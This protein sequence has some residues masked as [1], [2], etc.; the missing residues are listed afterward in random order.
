MKILSKDSSQFYE[1]VEEVQVYLEVVMTPSDGFQAC[2][3]CLEVLKPPADLLLRALFHP[4][5][6]FISR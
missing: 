4:F 3:N 1:C 2:L 6:C 5:Q